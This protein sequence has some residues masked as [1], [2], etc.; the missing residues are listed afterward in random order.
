MYSDSVITVDLFLRP[1]SWTRNISNPSNKWHPKHRWDI[2]TWWLS[3]LAGDIYLLCKWLGLKAVYKRRCRC[4][5]LRN[6]VK[7]MSTC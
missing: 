5:I 1:K 6:F 7:A 2:A 4:E 3:A